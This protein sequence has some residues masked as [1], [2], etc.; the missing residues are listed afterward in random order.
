M[1]FF[2]FS[3]N[4]LALFTVFVKILII[5]ILSNKPKDYTFEDIEMRWFTVLALPFLIPAETEQVVQTSG[6]LFINLI[7]PRYIHI[8]TF[9]TR[10][11]ENVMYLMQKKCMLNSYN[12]R[13]L[14]YV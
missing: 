4:F 1:I 3:I 9:S 13:I 12:L 6:G 8:Y 2:L 10:T 14:I 5:Q 7:I 11:C